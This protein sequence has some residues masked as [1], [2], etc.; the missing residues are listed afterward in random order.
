ME[1]T[2]VAYLR[3]QPYGVLGSLS[4]ALTPQG[5][6]V[7]FAVSDQFE[8]LFDTLRSSRKY[9]N[10]RTHPSVS[11]TVGGAGAA[12]MLAGGINLDERTVQYEGV[13]DEL[14]GGALEQLRPIYY[15][16]WPDGREREQWNGITWFVVRPRWLR[17]SD[18]NL[19]LIQEWSF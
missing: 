14:H 7:G 18:Y 1:R 15:A 16:A 5:A 12:G 10:L 13:A 8:I 9:T 6:L 19:S 3:T 11:F 4:P 2:D 17:Y